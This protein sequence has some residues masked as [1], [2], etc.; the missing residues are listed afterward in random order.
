MKRVIP[1]LKF[2]MILTMCL[3]SPKNEIEYIEQISKWENDHEKRLEDILWN[4]G[5]HSVVKKDLLY[6]NEIVISLRGASDMSYA[7]GFNR[8]VRKIAQELLI[9][10][11]Y[12]LRFYL[13][14][15]V[16][17]GFMGFGELIYKFKY[18]EKKT[19]YI[20]DT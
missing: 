10:D 15:E 12:K 20:H 18:T 9:K 17:S 13:E 2:N 1:E 4:I 11:I 14:C 5:I 6:K 16:K 19:T 7:I 8:A 3:N